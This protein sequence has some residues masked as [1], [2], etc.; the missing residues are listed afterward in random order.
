MIKANNTVILSGGLTRDPEVQMDGKLLVLSL[1]VDGAG[2]EKD[3]KYASGYFDIKFWLTDSKMTA[4]ATVEDVQKG[5]DE[6]TLKKGVRVQVVGSLRHER[7]TK[8]DKKDSRVVIMAESISF[9][10]GA[11]SSSDGET[12]NTTPV[13][14]PKKQFDASSF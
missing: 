1:A 14:T 3:V 4:Q 9:Y 6:G 11:A 2:S 10:S 5:L 8:E 12:H 13:S 7:W